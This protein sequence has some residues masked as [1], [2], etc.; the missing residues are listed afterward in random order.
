MLFN[1]SVAGFMHRCRKA[2]AVILGHG[3]YRWLLHH[4]QSVAL[5]KT[6]DRRS[7]VLSIEHRY[8]PGRC[9]FG[10]GSARFKMF[11]MIRAPRA[12]LKSIAANRS[13]EGYS[14]GGGASAA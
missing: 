14:N 8:Q 13:R 4:S 12:P 7:Q 1:D 3:L 5:L 11:A 6:L 9:L 10:V 2:A